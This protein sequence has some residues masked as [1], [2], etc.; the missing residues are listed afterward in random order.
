[1]LYCRRR[2][3]ILIPSLKSRRGYYAGV[4]APVGRGN[5]I[6]AGLPAG[7]LTRQAVVTILNITHKNSR[8]N[9]QKS[10]AL[11]NHILNLPKI[12]I[13]MYVTDL[14]QLN[15]ILEF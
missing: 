1:M 6:R 2:C 4:M 14:A 5:G 10:S 12:L 11:K 7:G 3:L 8:Q 9:H 15:N 13:F